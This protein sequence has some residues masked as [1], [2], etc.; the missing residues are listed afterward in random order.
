MDR[1]V[2]A[3]NAVESW[4]D[5]EVGVAGVHILLSCHVERHR[6][7]RNPGPVPKELTDWLG[8]QD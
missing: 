3:E 4:G 2:W 8:S 6:E 1:P 7:A 5:W